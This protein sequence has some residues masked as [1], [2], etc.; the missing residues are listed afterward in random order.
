LQD[1]VTLLGVGALL[2]LSA[3]LGLFLCGFCAGSAATPA[4]S[5][6]FAPDACPSKVFLAIATAS[7]VSAALAGFALLLDFVM[8]HTEP[9]GAITNPSPALSET[10]MAAERNSSLLGLVP[11][12]MTAL[13]L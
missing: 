9:S 4:V 10:R 7:A 5:A 3:G 8:T 13:P 1:R 2:G 6:F 12:D 11:S